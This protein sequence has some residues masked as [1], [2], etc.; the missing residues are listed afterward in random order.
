MK[1]R[2]RK[3]LEKQTPKGVDFG[4]EAHALLVGSMDFVSELQGSNIFGIGYGITFSE[5][6][7]AQLPQV[8]FLGEHAENLVR[9][10]N[11]FEQWSAK[12]DGDVLEMT[13]VFLEAGGYLVGIGPEHHR[14][15]QRVSRFDRTLSPI[16]VGA[17]WSKHLETRSPGVDQFRHYKRKLVSP[18]VLGAATYEGEVKKDSVQPDGIRPCREVKEILKF[19]C[20]LIDE[21]DVVEKTTASTILR[22]HQRKL[23]TSPRL[24]STRSRMKDAN[25]ENH[26]R[27]REEIFRRHFAVL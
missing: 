9:A 15:I 6:L 5:K 18:F 7:N 4:S 13:I 11:Q 19:E 14:L 12:S 26:L 20:T 24:T 10:F 27:R 8:S 2:Q 22:G 16:V 3:R 23:P 21:K 1:K 17:T 25:P